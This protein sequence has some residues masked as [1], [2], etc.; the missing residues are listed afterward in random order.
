MNDVSPY[1]IRSTV[2]GQQEIPRSPVVGP[3]IEI[4][5]SANLRDYWHVIKKH[6]AIIATCLFAAVVVAAVIV[7][8]TTPIYTARTTLLIERKE[9]QVVDV[10]NVLSESPESDDNDYYKTQYEILKS[11]TLAAQTIQEQGLEKNVVFTGDGDGGGVL[12]EALKWLQSL[13]SKAFALINSFFREPTPVKRGSVLGINSELV[14]A[15]QGML[16]VEPIQRT[17]LVKIAFN[18]PDPQFS[19]QVANAHADAYIRQGLKLRSQANQEAQSFLE[20]K[21]KELKKRVEESEAALNVYRREKGIISLDEKENIVVERLVDLNKRLTEAE[22]ERIGLEAQVHLIRRRDY[23]SLPAVI[24]S[25]L[26]SS[27]KTQLTALQGEYANLSAQFKAGYPKLAQ[28]KASLEEVELRLQHEIRKI[29]AGIV[30]TY[31]AARGK[32]NEL[33]AKMEQQKAATLQLKDAAVDYAVLAREVD[34]NRQLYDSVLGRM[35]EVGVAAEVRASNI[36]VIDKAEPPIIPSSPNK[37][38]IL[39]L[40]ALLGLMGG[41]GLALFFEHLDDTL[42]TSEDAERYLSLPN[43]GLVPELPGSHRSFLE[44]AP[45][46]GRRAARKNGNGFSEPEITFYPREPEEKPVSSFHSSGAANEAYRTLRT[47]ILLSKAEQPPKT[48]LFTSAVHGEG[49]T[50]T[51]VNSAMSFA[52]MGARVLLIDADLRRPFCHKILGLRRGL[53]VAELLRGEIQP[54]WAIQPTHVDNLFFISSG[55]STL[56]PTEFIGSMKMRDILGSVRDHYDYILVD[57]PPVMAV[58]DALLL[59][60]MVDGVVVVIGGQGTPRDTVKQACSRLHYA[61][62][63]ILGTMLNRVNTNG[64]GYADYYDEPYHAEQRT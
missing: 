28:V 5:E 1:V 21:L 22:A 25:G 46:I 35:K 23:D 52:R 10:K 11:R 62:A 49:K 63:K 44:R 2:P 64:N 59:S 16:E 43:L 32:E 55:S 12:I 24:N 15:Y 58:S 19:A 7:L 56:D 6:K 18:T 38:Q 40:A 45:I 47:G 26:I 50:A 42:K 20:E 14:D 34:T 60:T 31:L 39:L 48:V 3:P 54:S 41:L 37:K 61:H 53:G 17:R 30:S 36:F 51:V 33:R 27:L 13:P 9:P 4:S 57:S 29:V 8:M